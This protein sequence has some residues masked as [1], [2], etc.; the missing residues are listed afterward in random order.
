MPDVPVRIGDPTTAE[1]RIV[2]L[3]LRLVDQLHNIRELVALVPCDVRYSAQRGWP[4]REPLL[5]EITVQTSSG[6]VL[7]GRE[8]LPA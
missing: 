4:E 6:P 3:E 2:G 1:R 8:H 5:L 7:F